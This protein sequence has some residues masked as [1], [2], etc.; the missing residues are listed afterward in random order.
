MSKEP[1][2][3]ATGTICGEEKSHFLIRLDSSGFVVS[4]T[5]S[6]FKFKGRA[7]KLVCGQR[8]L[9]HLSPYSPD[10]GAIKKIFYDRRDEG[11]A[12]A[13]TTTP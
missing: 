5:A 13:V 11:S 12:P 2:I 10:R 8:C 6:L 1:P 7:K 3:E 9:V 4:C